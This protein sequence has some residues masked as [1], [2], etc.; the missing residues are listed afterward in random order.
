VSYNLYIDGP[1]THLVVNR[2]D[3]YEASALVNAFLDIDERFH[4]D[5]DL[6]SAYD[7]TAMLTPDLLAECGGNVAKLCT[8]FSPAED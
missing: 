3:A 2:A 1:H 7:P 4:V 6:W 8:W 5:S